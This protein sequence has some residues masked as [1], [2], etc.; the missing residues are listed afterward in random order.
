MRIAA[1]IFGLCFMLPLQVTADERVVRLASLN[2]PPYSGEA[3]PGQGASI[4]VVRTA[5][6]EMDYQLLVEFFPWSRVV[7]VAEEEG[8]RFHGYFPEYFSDAI[9]QNFIY[10]SS[11]GSG[12]LGFVENTEAPVVWHSLEDLSRFRIGVVSDYVNTSEFDRLV[13]NGHL[14]VAPVVSDKNNIQKVAFGRIDIAVID[15][16]LLEYSIN[17]DPELIPLASKVRFNRHLLELKQLYVCLRRNYPHLAK[18]LDEGLQR[19]D[20]ARIQREYLQSLNDS[21]ERN[22]IPD[23]N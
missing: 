8:S 10:S 1:V 17:N 18:V 12:P 22:S 2:W 23:G 15:Q 20:I 19:I 6:A 16:N 9:S 7:H 11:I 5:L 14:H 13:E 3:L 4:E 21:A